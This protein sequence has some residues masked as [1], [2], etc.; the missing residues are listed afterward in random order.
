MEPIRFSHATYLKMTRR[1]PREAVAGRG[2][3]GPE[4]DAFAV[5]Q[6]GRHFF[7]ATHHA[8]LR[9]WNRSAKK[10]SVPDTR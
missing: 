2:Q 1:T 8:K 5:I 9:G 6:R 7:R 4:T 10:D 3:A